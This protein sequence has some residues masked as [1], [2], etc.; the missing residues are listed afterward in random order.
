ME[1]DEIEERWTSLRSLVSDKDM[2][3]RFQ[4]DFEPLLAWVED[5]YINVL[6]S[7]SVVFYDRSRAKR[8]VL[9]LDGFIIASDLNQTGT[10]VSIHDLGDDGLKLQVFDEHTR[11]ISISQDLP[12]FKTSNLWVW[13]AVIDH[14]NTNFTSTFPQFTKCLEAIYVIGTEDCTFLTDGGSLTKRIVRIYSKVQFKQK[15]LG[16]NSDKDSERVYTSFPSLTSLLQKQKSKPTGESNKFLAS[17]LKDFVRGEE[18]DFLLCSSGELWEVPDSGDPKV[19]FHG[20]KS[21]TLLRRVITCLTRDLAVY[22]F[23]SSGVTENVSQSLHSLEDTRPEDVVSSIVENCNKV[24]HLGAEC[25]ELRQKQDQL[26]ALQ[27]FLTSDES[28]FIVSLRVDS[29]SISYSCN[30]LLVDFTTSSTTSLIGKQWSLQVMIFSTSNSSLLVKNCPISSNFSQGETISYSIDIPQV[31]VA[32]LPLR[33]EGR[34]ILTLEES[35]LPPVTVFK[36]SMNVSDFLKYEA[37]ASFCLMT[38]KDTNKHKTDNRT[39]FLREVGVR[40]EKKLNQ[41]TISNPTILPE[42]FRLLL[43]SNDKRRYHLLDCSGVKLQLQKLLVEVDNESRFHVLCESFSAPLLSLLR[44]E[45]CCLE[46]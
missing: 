2:K 16:K 32:L 13:N 3:D 5:S 17:E 40:C 37:S 33:V 20:V 46:Q 21:F 45:L 41:F 1:V 26:K 29:S 22:T 9:Q 38:G 25:G 42:S 36:E 39:N 35:I 6:T 15:Y 27:I 34:L 24:K 44:R 19:L 14:L 10:F 28:Y 7:S 31:S 43:D 8:K 4:V 11:K 18:R 23:P 12:D 30:A